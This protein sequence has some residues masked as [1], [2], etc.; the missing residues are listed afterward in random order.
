M[1]SAPPFE[2]AP[3]LRH[4]VEEDYGPPSNFDSPISKNKDDDDHPTNDDGSPLQAFLSEVETEQPHQVEILPTSSELSRKARSKLRR[5]S[6]IGCFCVIIVVSA[7]MIPLSL[8]VLRRKKIV[9]SVNYLTAQPTEEPSSMP[10]IQPSQKPSQN[11]YGKYVQTLSSVSNVTDILNH[12]TPQY[13]A[14][15]WIYHMDPYGR[16]HLSDPRLSQRYIAAVFYFSTAG[17]NNENS[18]I[19]C[20]P[21]DVSCT[22]NGKLSWFGPYD[23]CDWFGFVECDEQGFLTR[24]VM[25][26]NQN[27][28][29]RTNHGNN[30]AGTLPEE[31]GFW[32]SLKELTIARNPRLT[33]TIPSTISNL[34]KLRAL[35]LLQNG[36]VG[37]WPENALK[38]AGL[39][40][41]ID[42]SNN[43]F[44]WQTFPLELAYHE[45]LHELD[46]A[47]NGIH[48]MIPNELGLL[49]R[50]TLL[51]LSGNDLSGSIPTELGLLSNV[52][53][54]MLASNNL[55]GLIPDELGELNNLHNLNL[56]NN[57]L[58]GEIPKSLGRL[59][60][61][62]LMKK[63]IDLSGNNFNKT[64]PSEIGN[65]PTLRK[66]GVL[67]I[68]LSSYLIIINIIRTK[69]MIDSLRL[70][71][72]DLSG[73]MPTSICSLRGNA[74]G[75]LHILTVDH[76]KVQCDCCSTPIDAM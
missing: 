71:G 48:G 15:R 14:L 38:N 4:Q 51:E 24:F 16:R 60:G 70:D 7:I 26:N 3:C 62:T 29:G 69:I 68:F 76:D 42:L 5:Y 8:T 49:H 50:L 61:K 11:L 43:A 28:D 65:V 9:V 33:G 18:W 21:G 72:N 57:T 44:N 58:S 35:N 52:R 46:L 34:T 1:N 23:E 66:F 22:S 59:G 40:K 32:T 2:T 20:F 55:E 67:N 63:T 56:S 75:D 47:G 19:D 45:S 30:L 64:I 17:S 73:E 54:L 10:S 53:Y 31:I 25:I 37:Q 36:F 39:L 13:K 6:I 12:T 27:S 74:Y 41:R